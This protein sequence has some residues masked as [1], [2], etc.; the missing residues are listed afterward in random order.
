MNDSN[1]TSKAVI[2]VIIA[3]VAIVVIIFVYNM[4]KDGGGMQENMNQTTE[5]ISNGAN[6]LVDGTGEVANDVANGV[7]NAVES[8]VDFTN[9]NNATVE[10]NM[11]TNT[12]EKIKAD[13]KY[14]S[15]TFKEV[16]LVGREDGTTF[17]ATIKN[18][19]DN[20]FKSK[21]VTITFYNN[22]GSVITS[23]GITIPDVA[24]NE[25]TTVNFTMASDVANAYDY[26]VE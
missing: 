22:D 13:K 18:N 14:E 2:G 15:L 23:T 20:D 1:N 7:S 5:D 16:S 21:D 3:I 19:S 11:K 9:M 24:K 4:A 17:S 8:L 10:N 6:N 26:T 25:E 12:S